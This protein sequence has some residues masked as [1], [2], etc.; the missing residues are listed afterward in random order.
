MSFKLFL[1][2]IDDKIQMLSDALYKDNYS[3]ER[4]MNGYYN[5]ASS[6]RKISIIKY[7]NESNFLVKVIN[8][9]DNSFVAEFGNL[10]SK[11][12]SE[13]MSLIKEYE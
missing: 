12:I 10:K 4:R 9:S 5:K 13:I 11:N 7:A 6:S 3:K 2:N 8:A 1:E